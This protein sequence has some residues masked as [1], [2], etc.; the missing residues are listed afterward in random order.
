MLRLRPS[1]LTLTP[2]D[3]EETLARMAH[4]KTINRP[5]YTS[6]VGQP[7]RPVLR[8][9]PQRV[10]QDAITT[11]GDIPNLRPQPRQAVHASADEDDHTDSHA[12]PSITR[13][14]HADAP[15]L[16]ISGVEQATPTSMPSMLARRTLHLPFRFARSA[17]NSTAQQAPSDH[18]A[19]AANTS[20]NRPAEQTTSAVNDTADTN[21]MRETAR[22]SAPATPNKCCV[23][24]RGG[25]GASQ[26]KARDAADR[27]DNPSHSSPVHQLQEHSASRTLPPPR[28]SPSPRNA[29]S[30]EPVMHLQ[31][32]FTGQDDPSYSF[33]VLVPRTEPRPRTS[34]VPIPTRS[35][36][37]DNIPA[38][39]QHGYGQGMGMLNPM[40]NQIGRG[41]AP[42][43]MNFQRTLLAFNPTAPS[44]D[45]TAPYHFNSRN[46]NSSFDYQLNNRPPWDAPSQNPSAHGRRNQF[47]SES[48]SGAFS[49]YELPPESRLSSG[50][51]SG[52][53]SHH[54]Q[55]DGQ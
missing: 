12:Q 50:G 11:L 53:G 19:G 15:G 30:D 44:F 26:N 18:T 52:R 41:T 10:V 37:F 21:D 17:R 38:P 28:A 27:K 16:P 49:V 25:G 45:P 39:S 4:R 54:G 5:I 31:G 3:V 23:E 34:R 43:N 51:Q 13:E 2:E 29:S 9:G 14:R 33:E 22:R 48:S 24:L 47:T 35:A 6:L 8:R 36:S 55:Y 20:G 7:G 42:Q 32:F 1:E 40:Q 46:R